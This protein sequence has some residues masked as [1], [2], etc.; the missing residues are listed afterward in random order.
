MSGH[1]WVTVGQYSD[2]MSAAIV[3]KRLSE[4]GVP[5]RVWAPPRASG[6]CYIWVPPESADAAKEILAEP[7]VP[8][9]ELTALALKD[10]PPDDFEVPAS[11][12]PT[13]ESRSVGPIIRS[14]GT[15]GRWLIAALFVGLLVALFAYVPRIQSHEIARQRSPDGAADAVLLEVS[16]DDAEGHAYKV[17]IQQASEPKVHALLACPEVAYLGGVSGD[18]ASQLPVTLVWSS[19]SQLEIR[20]ANATSVHVYQPIF[21]WGSSRY[22][23]R[24]GRPA[25]LIK[26]VQ[27]GRKDGKLRAEFE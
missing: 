4:E 17:C 1:D 26:A 16:R 21:T 6:D 25:V 22:Y 8:E 13:L 20:Y 11:K 24:I 3:S 9:E 5:N 10:S 7:A 27:T 2:P 15:P 14:S 23:R 19:S 18:G 12:P